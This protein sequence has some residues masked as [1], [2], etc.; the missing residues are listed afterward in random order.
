MGCIVNG[1]GEMAG[2]NYG[3]V[4]SGKNEVTLYANGEPVERHIP[5]QEAVTRLVELIKSKNDWIDAK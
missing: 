1:P 4:G 3:V 2:A 5:E